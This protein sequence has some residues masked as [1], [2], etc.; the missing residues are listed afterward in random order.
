MKKL[1]III[2]M[3]VMTS[4]VFATVEN[5][6]DSFM[7]MKWGINAAEFNEK[8]EY[9]VKSIG[10]GGWLGY[11][12]RGVINDNGL[13]ILEGFYIKNLELGNLVTEVIMFGFEPLE[14]ELKWKEKNFTKFKFSNAIIMISSNDFESMLKILKVKYGEPKNSKEYQQQ[15]PI[16]QDKEHNYRWWE[17]HEKMVITQMLQ[18]EVTWENGNRTIKLYNYSHRNGEIGFVM[19]DKIDEDNTKAAAD[20]L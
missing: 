7:G 19:F 11:G 9:E 10:F 5:P 2:L 3:L 6:F 16:F 1:T 13:N 12:V 8:Y 14:N 4:F 18:H 20:V 17:N 15:I